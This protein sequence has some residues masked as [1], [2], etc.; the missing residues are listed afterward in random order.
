MSEEMTKE[1]KE[2]FEKEM[3][4]SVKLQNKE[5]IRKSRKLSQQLEDLMLLS[6]EAIETS[7]A[8]LDEI[9]KPHH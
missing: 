5:L 3:Y 4:D 6:D 8:L 7:Q 2:L 1:E 9:H